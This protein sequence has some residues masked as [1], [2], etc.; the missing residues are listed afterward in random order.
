VQR[1]IHNNRVTIC[2]VRKQLGAVAFVRPIAN[3]LYHCA[4]VQLLLPSD[5][6]QYV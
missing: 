4:N 1:F 5:E 6:S 3:H 2:F